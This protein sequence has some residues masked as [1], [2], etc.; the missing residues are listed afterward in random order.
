MY[1]GSGAFRPRYVGTATELSRIPSGQYT[2]AEGDTW[3]DTDNN[4]EKTYDGTT[5][6]TS[7]LRSTSKVIP[8]TA[9]TDSTGVTGVYTFTDA[10]PLGAVV[11]R[12][13]L[14]DIVGFTGDTSATIQVGDGTDA[15]RYSTGTPSV[16]TTIAALDA[17][18]VSGTIYHAAAKLPVITVTA[19]SDWGDVVAGTVTVTI[20]YYFSG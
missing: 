20:F 4:I 18:A 11:T 5:W 16:F 8:Y 7:G 15:D 14:S 10:I 3:Y 9:F 2:A 17:G 6:N 19:G 13:L 12:T 1:K